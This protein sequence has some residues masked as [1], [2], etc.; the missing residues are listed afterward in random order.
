MNPSDYFY[1]GKIVRTVGLKGE[2]AVQLDVDDPS[3]YRAVKSV[4]IGTKEN[5]T[6]H[7]IRTSRVNGMQLVI[8]IEDVMDI[9]AAKKWIG[10][11]IY[12]PMKKLPVLNDKRF[13]H[14]EIAGFKV[15]DKAHGEIGIA[16]E[17]MERLMQDVLVVM[18]ERTEI[19]I[20]LSQGVV[21]KVDRELKE[22][23]IAA[24][25]GLIDI[26]LDKKSDEE[27]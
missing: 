27:E 22:L 11:E 4:F 2:F 26:Y 23:H 18:Q 8:S 21:K 5:N 25:E 9:D 16:K 10:K 20:P 7:A 24:P 14:H 15:F 3:K 19:L 12:L 17:V 6:E 1:L 13:Y